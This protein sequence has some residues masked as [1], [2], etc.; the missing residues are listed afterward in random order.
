[1]T[2]G[3]RGLFGDGGSVCQ[4]KRTISVHVDRCGVCNGF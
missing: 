4:G 1:M 3:L 2:L